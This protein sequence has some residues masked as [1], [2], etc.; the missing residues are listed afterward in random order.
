[1]DLPAQLLPRLHQLF[2]QLDHLALSVT[3]SP[4]NGYRNINLLSIGYACRPRL[5]SR[6]TQS[7]RTFLWKPWVFG[8]WDSHPRAAT[9]TG[10]LSS[11]RST[12]P[13]DHA[14]SLKG[15]LPYQLVFQFHSFGTMLSPGKFSAQSHSTS[16]LLRTL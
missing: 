15:T 1:M 8:A 9:H 7:G 10:I 3:P 16:E 2:R 5:R 11:F 14:S 12:C 13:F 4:Y 6:L